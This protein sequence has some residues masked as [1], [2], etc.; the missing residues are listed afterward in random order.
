MINFNQECSWLN[1]THELFLSVHK[2]CKIYQSCTYYILVFMKMHK[3]SFPWANLWFLA[4]LSWKDLTTWYDWSPWWEKDAY[5]YSRS[6]GQG[7]SITLISLISKSSLI[8]TEPL[9]L[10]PWIIF[11]F[12]GTW[13]GQGHSITLISLISK[14][15]L[16]QTEPLRLK[17]WIIFFFYGTWKGQG[18]L[19]TIWCQV[20]SLWTSNC[21]LWKRYSY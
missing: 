13:K 1:K 20:Y 21:T 8:Q 6:G 12:Y 16:T 10:K 2:K 9:R 17:P 4:H 18:S 7:H 3:Y 14:S 5:C 15:S 19:L 11:F